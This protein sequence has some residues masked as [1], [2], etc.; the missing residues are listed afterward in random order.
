MARGAQRQALAM[1]PQTPG[2]SEKPHSC[3]TRREVQSPCIVADVL[4]YSLE[5]FFARSNA[6]A[7]LRV[8]VKVRIPSNGAGSIA[9][10]HSELLFRTLTTTLPIHS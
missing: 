6:G 5:I 7:R 4:R 10:F 9:K 2:S 8:S 3:R 1:K